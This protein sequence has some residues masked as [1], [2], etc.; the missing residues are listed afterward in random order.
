MD[1]T[2][3]FCHTS[4]DISLFQAMCSLASFACMRIGEI[5]WS[6]ADSTHTTAHIHQ[7]MK[8]VDNSQVVEALKFTFVNF[9]H[10]YNQRPFSVDTSSELKHFV[11]IFA[12]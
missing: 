10:H 7:L 6:P 9:K 12:S 3:Q 2:A 1:S 4:Y 11:A 5:T 8:L